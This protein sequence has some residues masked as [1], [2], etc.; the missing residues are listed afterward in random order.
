MSRLYSQS[1]ITKGQCNCNRKCQL[2]TKCKK[3]YNTISILDILQSVQKEH[4]QYDC[5]SQSRYMQMVC[6]EKY[7]TH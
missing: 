2:Y 4:N 1:D 7:R 3:K 6:C 5:H